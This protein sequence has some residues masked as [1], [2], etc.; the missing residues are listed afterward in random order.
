MKRRDLLAGCLGAVSMAPL[1]R[2]GQAKP[3]GA[4]DGAAPA[5]ASQ[6]KAR[7]ESAPAGEVALEMASGLEPGFVRFYNLRYDDAIRWFRDEA[8]RNPGS[9]AAEN[10]LAEA[11]LYKVL[12]RAGALETQLVSGDNPFVRWPK[13]EIQP[14]EKTEFFGAI[15]RV[16]AMTDTDLAEK[17]DDAEAL[18]DRGVAFGLRANYRFFMEKSWRDALRDATRARELHGRVAELRPDFVDAR[19]VEGAHLYLVGSLPLFYR[20]LGFLI[21]FRGD[22]R[23]GI[24]ILESVAAHGVRVRYDAKVLLCAIYR[25]EDKGFSVKAIPLLRELMAA[26]PHNHLFRL[27][28]VQLYS[29]LGEEAEV[30]GVFKE[31]EALMAARPGY[32]QAMPAARF[33]YA[34]GTFEF[35][36][37]RYPEALADLREAVAGVN[38]LDLHTAVLAQMRLGQLYDLLGRR[39]DARKAYQAAITLAPESDAGRESRGYLRRPYRRD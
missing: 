39:E 32:F 21:G 5:K 29:D 23:E 8:R 33:A 6:R 28:L 22:R 25:R 1:A 12:F 36:Y 7:Q 31:M 17:P 34:K 4:E 35:W 37:R 9:A 20:M 27:E 30:D 24:R 18:Y 19:F 2:S 15:D 10:H 16:L 13:A 26:F 38:S 14:A 3:L 11:V